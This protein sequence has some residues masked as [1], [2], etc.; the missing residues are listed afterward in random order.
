M[1]VISIISSSFYYVCAIVLGGI[2]AAAAAILPSISVA[3][4]SVEVVVQG[5]A[6]PAGGVP[7]HRQRG[8]W[9]VAVPAQYSAMV[10]PG[11]ARTYP[12]HSWAATVI[13]PKRTL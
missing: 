13:S 2:P 4:F 6:S 10:L 9:G 8:K 11:P 3:P 5:R 1:C 12:L 7:F